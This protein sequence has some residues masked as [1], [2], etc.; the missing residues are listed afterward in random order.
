MPIIVEFNGLPGSGKTTLAEELKKTLKKKG[1][2]VSNF[3][4]KRRYHKLGELIVLNPMYWGL[5]KTFI[6]YSHLFENKKSLSII[7]RV[8]NFIRSYHDFIKS[9]RREVLI[10]DQGFVQGVISIAHQDALPQTEHLEDILKMTNL[11][12][13]AVVCV[14]CNVDE[15]V[16]N[17]RITSRPK[18][19]CRVETMGNDERMNTLTIQKENLAYLRERLFKICPNIIYVDANTEYDVLDNVDKIVR[20]ITGIE[21]K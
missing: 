4:F 1:Y 9:N 19:G 7:L 16:S 17:K 11:N 14:N 2:V 5:I 6:K 18:N 13:N 10:V 8:V 3:Y 21:N 12:S 15:V 20:V